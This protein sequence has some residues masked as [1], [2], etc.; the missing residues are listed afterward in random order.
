[1]PEIYWYLFWVGVVLI[2]TGLFSVGGIIAHRQHMEVLKVLRSYAE[3][4]M[5]P[6]PALADQLA[7]QVFG[8][9][10]LLRVERHSRGALL[11]GFLGAAFTASVAWQ[12]NSWI[13]D[14]GETGWALYAS[15]A[16]FAFFSYSAF[17]LLL[18]AV[19]TRDK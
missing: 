1:M 9:P 5:E 3:K 19:T 16:A 14:H 13:V 4:G 10:G 6:P 12:V 17:G 7:K 8:R 2:T 11:R 18:A 15:W